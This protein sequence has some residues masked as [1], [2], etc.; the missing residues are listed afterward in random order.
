MEELIPFNQKLKG[1]LKKRKM[2]IAA[3]CADIGIDRAAFFYK[4]GHKHHRIYYMGIAYYLG[5][6]V[7]DLVDGTDAMDVY[8]S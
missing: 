6:T 1:I 5:M 3:F 4:K 8:Y 2:S 7:E